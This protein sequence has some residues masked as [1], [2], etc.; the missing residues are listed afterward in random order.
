MLVVVFRCSFNDLSENSKRS[1][2]SGLDLCS[3]RCVWESQ[4]SE[5][6]PLPKV[7][8]WVDFEIQV[9]MCFAVCSWFLNFGWV[10]VGVSTCGLPRWSLEWRD[11]IHSD[12]LCTEL[13]SWWQ[14]V[15]TFALMR[16]VPGKDLFFR[17]CSLWL[18]SFCSLPCIAYPPA[19]CLS[20][21]IWC[22]SEVT[23]A[24]YSAVI[25]EYILTF[26]L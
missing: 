4:D 10:G 22:H 3:H 18:L 1:R 23:T 16:W 14:S 9:L 17:F 19:F 15:S 26:L 12:F 7:Q 20:K 6:P 21:C 24:I 13:S 8:I 5:Q 2:Y 11:S 25:R